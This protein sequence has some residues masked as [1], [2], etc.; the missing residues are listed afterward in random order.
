MHPEWNFPSNI[1]LVGAQ[2]VGTHL[3]DT[4]K[5]PVNAGHFTLLQSNV[6]SN[7]LSYGQQLQGASGVIN[8]NYLNGTYVNVGVN[9]FTVTN[10]AVWV[11]TGGTS[12]DKIDCLIIPATNY[13]TQSATA[14]CHGTYTETGTSPSAFV[15]I[16]LSGC[17]IAGGSYWI[18]I[19]TNDN[20]VQ[21]GNFA[22]PTIGCLNGAT[23]QGNPNYAS[24]YVASTYGTYTGLP[25]TY[26]QPKQSEH[27]RL[28]QWDDHLRHAPRG[29]RGGHHGGHNW[30]YVDPE[31]FSVREP[32]RDSA[33]QR[34]RPH[35]SRGDHGWSSMQLCAQQSLRADSG[36]I[37]RRLLLVLA[38]LFC[39]TH[40]RASTCTTLSGSPSQSTLQSALNSCGNGNTLQLSAGSTT[41]TSTVTLP[42]G[43]ILSGPVVPFVNGLTTPTAE[44]TAGSAQITLFSVT[45]S[46][47]TGATTGLEY[48]HLDGYQTVN[49]AGSNQSNISL[50]GNT[51]TNLNPTTCCGDPNTPSIYF[52]CCATIS[53]VI[54][55]NNTVGDSNSCAA[56]VTTDTDGCGIVVFAQC[57]TCVGI[58]QNWTIRYN[59]F[60]HLEEAIHFFATSYSEGENASYC[61]NCDIEYNLFNQIHRIGIEF[62]INIAS[63]P[64][65]ES[66]NV[67]ENPLNEEAGRRH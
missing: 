64:L 65:I 41:V 11:G 2:P 29:E 66:N 42:C 30:R 43:V 28:H 67:F 26:S 60:N 13:N 17:T 14:S 55:E 21:I 16:P 22:C 15:N 8:S 9:S 37:M 49:F 50:I 12:G 51:L 25:T 4:V 63:N 48:L 10:C 39:A 35:R 61:N 33:I 47:T 45:G 58:A 7:L 44:I 34:R 57:P 59:Y 19:L 1:P 62:Q 6:A 23:Y 56:S 52:E 40:A 54:I 18:G 3:A 53:N 32:V 38:L 46:C 36:A 27:L 31:Q 5:S 24:Y 20:A